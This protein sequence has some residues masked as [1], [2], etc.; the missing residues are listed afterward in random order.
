[1]TLA[2]LLLQHP[3]AVGSMYTLTGLLLGVYGL[4]PVRAWELLGATRRGPISWLKP[5][6]EEWDT[7][8]EGPHPSQE[9]RR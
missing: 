9:T 1:V 4:G 6:A 2:V 5:L 7:E 8:D 3:E